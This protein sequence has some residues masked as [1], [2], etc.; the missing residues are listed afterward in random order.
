MNERLNRPDLIKLTL[1]LE[2]YDEILINH[3]QA[4]IVILSEHR[5]I[6]QERSRILSLLRDKR[7]KALL[8]SR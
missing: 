5:N 8:L 4:K 2:Y 7:K 1:L 3:A 6:L